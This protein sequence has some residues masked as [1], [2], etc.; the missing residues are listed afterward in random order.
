MIG[1]RLTMEEIGVNEYGNEVKR[2]YYEK[3]SILDSIKEKFIKKDEI[4]ADSDEDE[5]PKQKLNKKKVAAV[6]AAG[7]AGLGA[8]VFGISKMRGNSDSDDDEE[9]Y[10]DGEVSDDDVSEEDSDVVAESEYVEA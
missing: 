10:L 7:A 6:V 5:K 8:L 4:P 3:D 9:Y 1:Y 2:K